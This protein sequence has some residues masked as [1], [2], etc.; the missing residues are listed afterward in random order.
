MKVQPS[1][2]NV[3][4]GRHVFTQVAL[5]LLCKRHFPRRLIKVQV[6]W[7]PTRGEL[8]QIFPEEGHAD[9]CKHR[10]VLCLQIRPHFE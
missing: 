1:R 8:H 3:I 10:V 7:I 9:D 6:V 5:V 4:I 2:A